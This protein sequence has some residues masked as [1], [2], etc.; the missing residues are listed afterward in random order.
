[1]EWRIARR[2]SLA[3]VLRLPAEASSEPY[4]TGVTT[5]DAM[6]SGVVVARAG[7]FPL[8]RQVRSAAN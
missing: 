7:C 6:I 8:H 1:M 5:E 4:T 2:L 3:L